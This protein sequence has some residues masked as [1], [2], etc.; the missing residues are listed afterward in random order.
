MRRP[1]VP[2]KRQGYQRPPMEDLCRLV[3]QEQDKDTRSRRERYRFCVSVNFGN[4]VDPFPYFPQEIEGKCFAEAQ[5]V[6]VAQQPAVYAELI[7]R[8]LFADTPHLMFKVPA[9]DLSERRMS[10][11]NR[12]WESDTGSTTTWIDASPPRGRLTTPPSGRPSPRPSIKTNLK[13][14]SAFRGR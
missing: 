5:D 4:S 7:C 3:Q 11:R 9:R 8:H 10:F 1:E 14:S 6:P 12:S 2:H 13:V